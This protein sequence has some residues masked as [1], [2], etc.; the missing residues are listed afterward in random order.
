MAEWN[1]RQRGSHGRQTGGYYRPRSAPG[2]ADGFNTEEIFELHNRPELRMQDN[3]A[4]VSLSGQ[5]IVEPNDPHLQE[6]LSLVVRGQTEQAMQANN[7]P[8]WGN[9]PAKGSVPVTRVH[10]GRGNHAHRGQDRL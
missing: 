6:L 5:L 9:Y 10:R 8:F 4:H 7:D 1:G 2:A 3:P